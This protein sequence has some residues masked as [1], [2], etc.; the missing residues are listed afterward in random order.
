[1]GHE[2]KDLTE[3]VGTK[4]TIGYSTFDANP[5][6]LNTG[7]ETR[8]FAIPF[9]PHVQQPLIQTVVDALNGEGACPSTGVSGARTSRVI[10][11]ILEEYRARSR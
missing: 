10:D 1:M 7:D 11:A 9:P 6:R 5:V 4:G 3:I 2:W 8:E